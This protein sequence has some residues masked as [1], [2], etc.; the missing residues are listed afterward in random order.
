MARIGMMQGRLLPP[1][2]NTIFHFPRDRWAEEFAL[3]AMAQLDCIEWIFDVYGA[4]VNPLAS[5]EG[6]VQINLLAKQNNIQVLSLCA[7]YFMDHLL[8]RASFS[9][10][11]E[12]ILKLEWL[13]RQSQKIG[14]R[15]IVLPFLDSSSINTE[16]EIKS[17]IALLE[18]ISPEAEKAGIDLLL[19]SSLEPRRLGSL[20]SELPSPT[21]KINYD[22]GNSASLGY[23]PKDEF[24]AYGLR[25]GSV[26]IKDRLRTGGTV[27]LGTGNTNFT[28]I[29]DGLK[30]IGYTGDFIL[31]AARAATGDELTWAK[32]NREFIKN[33]LC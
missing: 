26:H 4:D 30:S 18:R 10:L 33:H 28:V 20:L 16:E 32:H 14:I 17:V 22:T 25:I 24:K 29:S 9:E 23:D 6:I 27:P 3:A 5:D 12:R 21:L 19:E 2:D 1:V 7:N 13:F 15:R 31:E 11:E 8:V